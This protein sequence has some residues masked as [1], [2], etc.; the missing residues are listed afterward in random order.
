MSILN[1]KGNSVGQITIRDDTPEIVEDQ[2]ETKFHLLVPDNQ[3]NILLKQNDMQFC[4]PHSRIHSL[5][6]SHI[7]KEMLTKVKK[8][9]TPTANDKQDIKFKECIIDNTLK[10][11]KK[12]STENNKVYA[13]DLLAKKAGKNSNIESW[14]DT[15]LMLPDAGY[16][17]LLLTVQIAHS[18]HIPLQLSPD[19]IWALIMQG[20]SQH[21]KQNSEEL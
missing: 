12:F 15:G 1:D 16:H 18:Y 19:D 17:S 10:P 20:M 6:D 5:T 9:N 4:D 3:A 14:G 21:I 2:D 11:T 13:R 8:N 7:K